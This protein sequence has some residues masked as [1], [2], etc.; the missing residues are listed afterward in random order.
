M[1]HNSQREQEALNP[2]SQ[3]IAQL[4]EQLR[5]AIAAEDFFNTAS[6][7]LFVK[8]ATSVITQITRDITSDKYRTN[9]VGYGLA[10][11]DLH[12][13][14]NILKRMQVAASPQRRAKLDERLE[15]K[16]NA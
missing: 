14:Q 3:E 1:N 16:K 15:E 4:E 10:L 11:S 9:H 2:Q 8:V 6:G 5:E 7:K 12:A 13:Y